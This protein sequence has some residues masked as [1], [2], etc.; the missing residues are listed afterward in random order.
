MKSTSYAD[1]LSAL[2]FAKEQQGVDELLFGNSKGDWSEGTTSN[3]FAVLEGRLVTPSLDSGCLPG[4]MRAQVLAWAGELGIETEERSI[5]MEELGSA[6]EMF[7]TSAIRGVVP[8]VKCNG[9]S[10][11]VGGLTTRLREVWR[12]RAGLDDG[13]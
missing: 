12:A 1:H 2:C 3:G 5:P 10:L 9:V 11:P 6:S 7:L 4:T 8:V 13:K